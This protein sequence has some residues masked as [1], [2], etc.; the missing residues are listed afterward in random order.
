[1]AV[2]NANVDFAVQKSSWNNADQSA[3]CRN[4][5]QLFESVGQ[6]A[7]GSIVAVN[8]ISVAPTVTVVIA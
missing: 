6:Q 5:S 2:P 3:C 8:G 1:M 7:F 4:V